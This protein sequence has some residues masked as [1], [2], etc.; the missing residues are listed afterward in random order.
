[1]R[2]D[3]SQDI[4]RPVKA[5]PNCQRKPEPGAQGDITPVIENLR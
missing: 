5:S 2:L 4:E 3:S 1:M